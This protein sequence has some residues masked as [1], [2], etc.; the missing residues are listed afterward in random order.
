MCQD[1]SGRISSALNTLQGIL[2]RQ[3]CQEA[4]VELLRSL[5]DSYAARMLSSSKTVVH[6]MNDVNTVIA[7]AR[8]ARAFDDAHRGCR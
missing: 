4:K 1:D 8:R 6:D 2:E 7:D 3:G 5:Q